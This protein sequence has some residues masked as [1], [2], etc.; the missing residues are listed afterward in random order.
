MTS[1][2]ADAGTHEGILSDGTRYLIEVSAAWNGTLLLYSYGPPVAPDDPPWPRDQ[3]VVQALLARGYAIAGCATTRFWPLEENVGNQFAVAD[4]FGEKVGAPER[5]VACG[6]SIGGLMTATLVQ[7]HPERLD[8][9]LVICG[10]LGG[11]VGTQNQQLDCTFAFKTLVAGTEPI[12]LVNIT[13]PPRNIQN[14]VTALEAAQQSPQGRARIGLAASLA[15]IP[16]WYDPLGPAPAENGLSARQ[17]AQFQWLQ[18]PDFQVFLGARAVLERRGGGNMSWNTGVDYR[19]L[20][21]SSVGRDDTCALYADAGLD[22]DAD[23][24]ALDRAPRIGAEPEAVAYFERH[25]AF[26][27]D[28]GETPVVTVHSLGDGLVPIDHMRSYADVVAWAGQ[29]ELLATLSI[30]RGGHCSFTVAE[31]LTALDVLIGR[32]ENGRWPDLDPDRLNAHA[33][34]RFPEDDHRLAPI[35][36]TLDLARDGDPA[37]PAFVAYDPP[38]M[39]RAHD[40]RHVMGG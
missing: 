20:L 30:A 35:M 6:H 9:A 7:S 10:T 4:I 23:L 13:A 12:E 19:R 39:A 8:A 1:S 29:R 17:H 36:R 33:N 18:D 26:N 21:E 2:R 15:N 24:D 31:T 32:M 38:P 25:I 34:A 3:P 27:G 22:L 16:G 28:L 37:P 14:A 5:T 40:V 11:G